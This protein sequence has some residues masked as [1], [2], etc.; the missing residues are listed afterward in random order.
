MANPDLYFGPLG[1]KSF[2][3]E[4][5]S[6]PT[7]PPAPALDLLLPGGTQAVT[8]LFLFTVTI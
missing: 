3:N 1:L 2:A 5:K 4:G 7:P 6:H 8:G